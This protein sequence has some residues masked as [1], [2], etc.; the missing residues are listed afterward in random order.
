M[1]IHLLAA[2]VALL[3]APVRAD[4]ERHLF[5]HIMAGQAS[6]SSAPA[7]APGANRAPKWECTLGGWVRAPDLS[8]NTRVPAEARLVAN[9]TGCGDIVGW[10]VGVRFLERGVF[11]R[12]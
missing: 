4:I 3:A 12:K 6:D 7:P 1:H 5:Q 11:K 8:P 9:G 2:L 10:G